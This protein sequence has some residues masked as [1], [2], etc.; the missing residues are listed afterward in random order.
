MDVQSLSVPLLPVLLLI[1]SACGTV[2]AADSFAE[3]ESEQFIE[4]V[5]DNRHINDVRIWAVSRAG[6]EYL[7]VV[8]GK[9][10]TTFTHP[11]SRP[12]DL[13]LLARTLGGRSFTTHA[14]DTTPGEAVE[15]LISASFTP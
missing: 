2:G 5:V 4:I 10:R 3:S 8:P 1:T 15:L 12:D 14:I 13:Q 7:G 11:W 6:N 9:D